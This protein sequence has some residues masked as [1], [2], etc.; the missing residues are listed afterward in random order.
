[1]QKDTNYTP[2]AYTEAKRIVES[3]GY[4]VLFDQFGDMQ[5]MPVG[6]RHDVAAISRELVKA[7]YSVLCIPEPGMTIIAHQNREELVKG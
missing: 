7:G 2:E 3:H 4:T 5:A 6:A 1:M